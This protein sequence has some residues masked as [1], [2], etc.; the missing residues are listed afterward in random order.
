MQ[1]FS[2]P[3]TL[4]SVLA[5]LLCE[6]VNETFRALLTEPPGPLLIVFLFT[7]WKKRRAIVQQAEGYENSPVQIEQ[8][9]SK[10]GRSCDKACC[11]NGYGPPFCTFT[12]I[13]NECFSVAANPR[14]P[15][16]SEPQVFHTFRGEDVWGCSRVMQ[17][18]F[19][20]SSA[21]GQSRWRFAASSMTSRY[22]SFILV[23]SI[24]V[25]M[26]KPGCEQLLQPVSL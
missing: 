6:K 20:M 23:I 4:K 24:A 16:M 13:L 8:L 2:N 10:R 22:F 7:A 14:F 26:A 18:W 3:E 21:S 5:Q 9:V 12:W 19:N 15:V 1:Q 11:S 25:V 17:N